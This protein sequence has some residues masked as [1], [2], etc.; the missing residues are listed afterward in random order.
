MRQILW[1]TAVMV[2]MVLASGAGRAQG[3]AARQKAEAA[4]IPLKVTVVVTRHKSDKA[5]TVVSRMPFEIWVNTGS[6]ATLRFGSEV[7]VPTTRIASVEGSEK[8]TPVTSFTYR[9]VGTSITVSAQDHGE[10]RYRLDVS[11]E[12]SQI[13]PLATGPD[14][15]G[16]RTGNQSFRSATQPI[17][18]DG[19]TVQHS[20]AT[21][22]VTG[23]VIK[24]EVTLNV[25]TPR[26]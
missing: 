16:P 12:D 5:Q 1:V 15:G 14:V 2:V 7:P 4:V 18:R 6:S 19:Q 9:S 10:G 23:D 3:P 26:A 21:D 20:L 22:I 13:I 25:V 8:N 24:A 11:I 17:L